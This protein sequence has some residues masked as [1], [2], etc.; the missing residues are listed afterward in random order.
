MRNRTT[1]KIA[2][3]PRSAIFSR[4]F[5]IRTALTGLVVTG[6]VFFLQLLARPEKAATQS[7][8]SP[9][10]QGSM[11]EA[12]QKMFETTCANGYCHAEGGGGSGPTNLRNRHFSPAEVIQIISE[13]VPGTDMPA[14]KTKYNR[15]QIIM[16]AA[17]VLSLS[18]RTAE[19]PVS[20]E[21]SASAQQSPLGTVAQRPTPIDSFSRE[22][23]REVGGDA[24]RGRSIFFDDAQPDN[25]AVCHTYGGKGGRVGPDLTKIASESPS[26]ISRSILKPETAA[27][28]KYVPVEVTGKGGQ[29]YVGVKQNETIDTI[30]LY[31]TSSMPPVLRTFLKSE[32]TS[33]RSL[34]GSV[35]PG[36]YGEKYSDQDL[37]DIVTYLKAGGPNSNLTFPHTR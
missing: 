33:T 29:K 30:R 14:W 18:P 6:C 28:S 20:T 10:V 2:T 21:S 37:L 34:K 27:D 25:C 35:M 5:L 3:Y 17:Y 15:D 13:G 32:V 16:L 22:I 4:Q 23:E 31:D 26:E 7:V 1:A 11:V 9:Q 36:D 24:S 8:P 12:G 19:S